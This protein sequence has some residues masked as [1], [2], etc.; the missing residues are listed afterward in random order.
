[1]GDVLAPLIVQRSVSVRDSR[2]FTSTDPY[3]AIE[4]RCIAGFGGSRKSH[5]E[6]GFFPVLIRLSFRNSC[7]GLGWILFSGRFGDLKRDLPNCSGQ[8]KRTKVFCGLTQCLSGFGFFFYRPP[9][10]EANIIDLVIDQLHLQ[11]WR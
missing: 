5:T 11:R 10:R 9:F 6:L 4:K 7:S 3:L 1:M 8:S 2:R